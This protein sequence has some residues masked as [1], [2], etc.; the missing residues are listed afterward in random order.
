MS[1]EK[2]DRVMWR[3]KK[4]FPDEDIITNRQLEVAIMYECGTSP[5][6]YQN[7]RKALFKLGY[8]ERVRAG[9]GK[10]NPNKVKLTN[11]FLT[12]NTSDYHIPPGGKV[13]GDIESEI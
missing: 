13:S 11:K 4:E 1:V 9:S 6:T 7:N 12:G 8:I 10:V 2:L 5:A 3:L